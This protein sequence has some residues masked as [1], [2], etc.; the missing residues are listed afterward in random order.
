[1]YI[2]LLTNNCTEIMKLLIHYDS[3]MNT[4][5]D[6]CQQYGPCPVQSLVIFRCDSVLCL[7]SL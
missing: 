3:V 2:S 1:M 7:D 6:S 5:I 4:N